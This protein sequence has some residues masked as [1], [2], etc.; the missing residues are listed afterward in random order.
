MKNLNRKTVKLTVVIYFL[1]LSAILLV[2]N[3]CNKS[4]SSLNTKDILSG[5][6]DNPSLGSTTQ[7]LTVAHM[8]PTDDA[9][10][11]EVRFLESER[12]FFV[13]KN[14]A[15]FPE[16][17]TSLSAGQ[18]LNVNFDDNSIIL[19]AKR[20]STQQVERYNSLMGPHEK[21]GGL[22]KLLSNNKIGT[23]VDKPQEIGVPNATGAL[24]NVI[25]DL[26]T[27]QM[28]FDYF[29]QQTCNLSGPFDIDYCIS[30]Q[31]TPDGCYARAH[32]MRYL[33]E[34]KY[35][36]RCYKVFSFANSSGDVLGVVA[37]KWG[38][39]CIRWWY[40]VAPL[41][42]IKTPSGNKSYVMDPAMFDTPVPLSSWLNAQQDKR[43]SSTAHVSMYSIQPATAYSP[44]NYAGTLFDTDPTYSQTNTTLTAYSHLKSCP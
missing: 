30:F 34:N 4:S 14:S 28:I 17:N 2:I 26:A 20:L 43:C 19:Q 9:K 44:S 3:S 36:Y 38:G 31:Y 13:E 35:H 42:T 5:A 16:L 22:T 18:P 33:L 15:A 24:T 8:Q 37:N 39:C 27:A 7:I 1:A 41:V 23:E 21:I 25:P 40:H 10:T 29:M 32:K 6:Y 12:I 11:L